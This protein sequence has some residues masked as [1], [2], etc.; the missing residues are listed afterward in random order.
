M[1]FGDGTRNSGIKIELLRDPR[2]AAA[3]QVLRTSDGLE[4]VPDRGPKA[5]SFTFPAA[6]LK[7]Q[8]YLVQLS[9]IRANAP[10]ELI[11]T[12]PF[13]AVVK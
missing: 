8:N 11:T 1:S 12:Y 9:G 13:R 5:V 6:L 7:Q 3:L 2:V 4:A 10:S